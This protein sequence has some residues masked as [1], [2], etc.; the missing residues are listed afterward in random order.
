M[1]RIREKYSNTLD[2]KLSAEKAISPLNTRLNPSPYVWPTLAWSSKLRILEAAVEDDMTE[3]CSAV[4]NLV[5]SLF[6]SD[7]NSEPHMARPIHP[8][9]VRPMLPT[10]IAPAM[11]LSGTSILRR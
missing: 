6:N 10:P 11:S 8:P 4:R 3:I 1:E 5:R 9:R 2:R 7:C